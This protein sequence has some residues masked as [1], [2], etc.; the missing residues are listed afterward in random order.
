MM[1]RILGWGSKPEPSQQKTNGSEK[2]LEAKQEFEKQA[3]ELRA[4]FREEIVDYQ[5]AVDSVEGS[6]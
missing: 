6:T 4:M 1:L 5:E 2:L 3:G